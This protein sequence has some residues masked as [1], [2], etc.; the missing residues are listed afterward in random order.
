MIFACADGGL[1]ATNIRYKYYGGKTAFA[2]ATLHT[3]SCIPDCAESV[4]H[5]F[6]GTILLHAV[7]RCE[8]VLYYTRA[9]VRFTNGAP[10]GGPSASQRDIEPVG[11]EGSICGR[12]LS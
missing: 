6:P 12:V 8:G 9:L 10:Y 5:A 2:T 4:F 3:H 7:A 1:I 11:E